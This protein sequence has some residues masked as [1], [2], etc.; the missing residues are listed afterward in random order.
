MGNHAVAR[1]STRRC[2][3]S[4]RWRLDGCGRTALRLAHAG[5]EH[6]RRRAVHLL[7]RRPQR[8]RRRSRRAHATPRSRRRCSSSLA[9][10]STQI[11]LTPEMVRLPSLLAGWPPSPASTCSGCALSGR[12][13]GL[14]AAAL[15]ALAPFMIYYSAEARGYARDDAAGGAL[16]AGDAAGGRHGRGALVGAVCAGL[17]ALPMYTHYTA[18][19]VLAAQ[20]AWLLWAHPRGAQAGPGGERCGRGWRSCPGCRACATTSS[21]PHHRHPVGAPA[22][23][24]ATTCGSDRCRTGRVGLS[25]RHVGMAEL[26]GV[27]GAGHARRRRWCW[28]SADRR[29]ARLPRGAR[30]LEHD[31][32]RLALVVALALA[33]PVPPAVAISVVGTNL[34]STRNLAASWP[35]LA[36][37]RGRAA[38]G[39]RRP[40]CGGGASA[41][42]VGG[43]AI[44]AGKLA[45]D[46]ATRARTTSRR[47][48]TSTGPREP[49]DVVIDETAR[50]QPRAAEP[51]RS[52]HRPAAHADPLAQAPAA[53]AAVLASST[54]TFRPTRQR[55]AP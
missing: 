52:V 10:L 7:D 43:L 5:P 9:W 15:T 4:G 6:L 21:S 50:A 45:F 19:F 1:P 41:L 40:R 54:P 17:A 51:H 14:V 22:V 49:D 42:A 33:V 46:D 11:D 44:A 39:P 53:R 55:G 36:R 32:H 37:G 38:G 16:D 2:R 20:L 29:L 23:R 12:A 30:R 3:G 47:R 25:V 13:A 34:F 18:A 26:P 27:T 28:A 24:P 31:D 35:A 48:G 8:A